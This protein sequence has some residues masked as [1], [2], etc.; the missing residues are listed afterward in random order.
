MSKKK[1]IDAEKFEEQLSRLS[2]NIV[3]LPSY[4]TMPYT[5]DPIAQAIYC[6][7]NLIQSD[8]DQK[9]KEVIKQV[10]QE[11]SWAVN[12][13][14][15]EDHPCLLCRDDENIKSPVEEYGDCRPP[16]VANS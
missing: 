13:C 16:K 15:Y 5:D 4:N 8:M 14:T 2:N 1:L 9:I 7:I 10:L 3:I 11:I 12:D 6:Q